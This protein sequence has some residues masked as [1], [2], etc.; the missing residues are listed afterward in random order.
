M[1]YLVLYTLT[2]AIHRLLMAYVVAGSFWILA[3]RILHRNGGHLSP[4]GLRIKEW[5]PFFLGLTITAGVAPV[6]FVQI[7]YQKSFYSANLLMFHRWMSMLPVLIVAFYLLYIQKTRWLAA[8][9]SVALLT[10]AG[11]SLSFVFI[12]WTWTENH[13]LSVNPKAWVEM[14]ASGH[15]YY[16]ATETAP[17]LA[18]WLVSTAPALCWFLLWQQTLDRADVR[19]DELD[20]RQRTVAL[21][22]I[23]GANVFLL[24]T[25]FVMTPEARAPLVRWS[26]APWWTAYAV[27]QLGAAHFWWHSTKVTSRLVA[28]IGGFLA[29]DAVSVAALRET[30][31]I[32]RSDFTA[33]LPRHAEASQVG[34]LIAFLVFLALNTGLILYCV[35]LVR[36]VITQ[37]RASAENASTEGAP[38]GHP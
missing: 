25:A 2:W 5:S 4:T 37:P 28:L 9:P 29:L 11:I 6:L 33:V 27:A 16:R 1:L 15:W 31:R 32:G 36:R 21:A 19:S 14:Y 13:L 20:P 18:F 38:Q 22:S 30:L 7:L 34:G 3:E 17:R 12:A 26:V 24:V 23:V 35:R 10:A 8:R